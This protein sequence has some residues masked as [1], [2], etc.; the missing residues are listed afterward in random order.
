MNQSGSDAQ[1][2]DAMSIAKVWAANTETG[3]CHARQRQE[4]GQLIETTAK[5]DDTEDV[6]KFNRLQE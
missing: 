3:E 2:M 1:T 5:E 6:C 4:P